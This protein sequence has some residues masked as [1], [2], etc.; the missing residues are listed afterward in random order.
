MAVDTIRV[1][2]I[3]YSIQGESTWA[4]MP[5]AFVRLTG[6]PLRCRYCDTSYAFKEGSFR[7]VQEII[8]EVQSYGTSLVEITGGE[9]L[10]QPAVH[11]LMEQLCDLGYQVLLET[12]GERDLRDCD[13]RVI[14]IVDIKTP[15]SGAGGSFL[16]SNY[17]ALLK[18]DEIKFVI[19]NREDFDWAVE[20]VAKKKL[21]SRVNVIHLSPV[22]MQPGDEH[23]DGCEALDP[24][25]LA[26]WILECGEQFRLQLQ[27]HKYIW[28][29]TLRGV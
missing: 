13:Q 29:P 15:C 18:H 1:N 25:T 2:E 7:T 23:I 26:Q 20:V 27:V 22:M 3:F 24:A 28:S 19:T 10:I 4:G 12:S 5:C 8:E 17:D 9:P 6:C 14:K 16:E 21:Q 11:P